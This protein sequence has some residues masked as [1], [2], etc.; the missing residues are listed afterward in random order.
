MLLSNR[1]V[2]PEKV[3]HGVAHCVNQL[4]HHFYRVLAGIACEQRPRAIDNARSNG[5]HREQ[6]QGSGQSNNNGVGGNP[7]DANR[8]FHNLQDRRYLYERGQRHERKRQESGKTTTVPMPWAD[9]RS[10]SL[11]LR[12]QPPQQK[13]LPGKSKTATP[14]PRNN[15][16]T[17]AG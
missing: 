2:S 14:V 3:A 9:G 7:L 1:R 16:R 12:G 6:R 8:A 15:V 11:P 5:P 10:R 17:L 13:Q 4:A